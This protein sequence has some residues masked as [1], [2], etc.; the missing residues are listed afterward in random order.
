MHSLHKKSLMHLFDKYKI[1]YIVEVLKSEYQQDYIGKDRSKGFFGAL[2]KMYY[3]ENFNIIFNIIILI[4]I[5]IIN[6]IIIN[7]V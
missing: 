7:I 4:N 3:T 1:F 6:I 2:T 5:I